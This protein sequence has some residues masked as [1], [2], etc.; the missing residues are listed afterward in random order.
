MDDTSEVER[1]SD[2]QAIRRALVA[3]IDRLFGDDPPEGLL[4]LFRKVDYNFD[5]LQVFDEK[6]PASHIHV[7]FLRRYLRVMH[8]MTPA[9]VRFLL[10]AMM[11]AAVTEPDQFGDDLGTLERVLYNANRLTWGELSAEQGQCVREIA[12][13]LNTRHRHQSE[14]P[15]PSMKTPPAQSQIAA[16]DDETKRLLEEID[17]LF[18]DPVPEQPILL[19]PDG[20]SGWCDVVQVFD[21]QMPASSFPT[22]TLRQY[23][24]CCSMMSAA[25]MHFFMPAFLRALLLDHDEFDV[26]CEGLCCLWEERRH[27]L[28]RNGFSD[29]QI[30][31]IGRVIEKYDKLDPDD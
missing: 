15:A 3:K 12:V 7:M 2:D 29:A 27:V 6:Y 20:V 13:R 26:G 10:P 19:Y 21:D 23:G 14:H 18:G 24:E 1:V 9:A 31:C 11:R 16:A 5:E 4:L 22:G 25:A 28:Y 8:R 30:A 17:Q